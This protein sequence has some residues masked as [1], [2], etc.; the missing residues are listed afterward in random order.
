MV[1]KVIVWGREGV[2]EYS[3]VDGMVKVVE[4]GDDERPWII[5]IMEVRQGNLDTKQ[6]GNLGM[7]IGK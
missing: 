1:V 3:C 5:L 2:V 7:M 6:C 4:G